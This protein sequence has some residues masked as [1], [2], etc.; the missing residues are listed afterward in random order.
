MSAPSN[1]A[2]GRAAPSSPS[3]SL[4]RRLPSSAPTYF[5]RVG[6]RQKSSDE[7]LPSPIPEQ[8]RCRQGEWS[9]VMHLPVN[10]SEQTDSRNGN[11][12][13]ET[14]IHICPRLALP[15]VV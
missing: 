2:S 11:L 4:S 10:G 1:S 6:G 8:L 7:V 3:P 13:P 5:G 15:L 12:A 9:P 14:Y